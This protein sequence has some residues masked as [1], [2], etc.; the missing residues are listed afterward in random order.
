MALPCAGL[1]GHVWVECDILTECQHPYILLNV[2]WLRIHGRQTRASA[3]LWGVFMV[4]AIYL[5]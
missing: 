4:D 3:I 5:I 1:C 2:T